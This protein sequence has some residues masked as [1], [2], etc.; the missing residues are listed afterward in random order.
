TCASSP[1]PHI[2]PSV[3]ITH[4]QAIRQSTASPM[5]IGHHNHIIS[6]Y[7]DDI[8]L[9]LDNFDTSIH[10]I[11]KGFDHFS[12]LSG[13]K[14]YWTKSALMPLNN[15]HTDVPIPV[16]IQSKSSFTYLGITIYKYIYKINRDNFNTMLSKIKSDIHRWR[17]LKTSLQGRINTVKMNILPRL[18]FLFFMLPLC[19][20]SNDIRSMIFSFI[21]D[22][23][24]P[25]VH[26][27]T[28]ALKPAH[29]L[30]TYMEP[31]SHLIRDSR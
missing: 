22:G 18:N 20:P 15:V 8:I 13:Y 17:N 21:W 11:I 16:Y 26:L 31:T 4:S 3:T 9:F 24:W 29:Q 7:A 10:P 14:I 2:K 5:E 30:F 27:N 1:V 28:L 12:S 23:R 25:R 6:L 19:P